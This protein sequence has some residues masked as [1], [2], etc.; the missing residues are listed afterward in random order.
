MPMDQTQQ[1]TETTKRYYKIGEVEQLLGVP[2]ST[3]RYWEREFTQLRP[4]RNDRG[5]RYYTP[6]DIDTLRRIKYLLHDC[7][8]KIDAARDKLATASNSVATHQRALERLR[9]IRAT[10]Q[11]M[12][13]SLHRLR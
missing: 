13:D 8:M 9:S 5:T 12:L 2:Q 10:L 7:G 1:H 6:S 4:N 11:Q 3:L